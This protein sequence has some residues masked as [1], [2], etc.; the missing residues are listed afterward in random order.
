MEIPVNIKMV[1]E[2]ME[3]SGS[4]GLEEMVMAEKDGFLAG[5]DHVC[6]S[7]NYWLGK[8]KPCITYGLRGITYFF[9]EVE[10]AGRDLH[11][12][13][14]G[15]SVHEAMTDIVHLMGS[16]VD[17]KGR[18]QVDGIYDMV[19]P[20]TEAEKATYE[21][22]DFDP[23][24][25]GRDIDVKGRLMHEDKFGL[26]THRWR[27]PSLSLHGIEGA[28][29]GEGAKTVVPGKVIGKFSI[30]L[31]PDMDPAVVEKLVTEHLERKMAELGSP[32]SMKVTMGHGAPAFR[33]DFN[34]PNF[35]AGRA[36]IEAVWG[37]KPDL[38]REGGS[39]PITLTF[40]EATG[41]NLMLLPL[42][43]SDDGA[44]SQNEKMDR[45]AYINGIKVLGTY[46]FELAK[47]HT[48]E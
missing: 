7:D 11:S 48:A 22:I 42:G 21:A 44:H 32:N 13:V 37:M 16:L 39:I 33:A 9:V 10:C 18:I 45:V 2:G 24:A 27:Y 34:H 12:G 20:M 30:R 19:E 23:E 1:L 36:A 40:A 25:F 3:E 28:W 14:F 5:T 17:T 38:T 47:H 35:L 6:V 41:K 15:G 29:A 31:V 46:L 43:A 4:V 8:T 26:L